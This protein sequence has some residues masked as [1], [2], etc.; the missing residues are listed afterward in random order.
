MKKHYYL[1]ALVILFLLLFI[2]NVLV[3]FQEGNPLPILLGII[4]V[5][6]SRGDIV[7]VSDTKLLQK[8]GPENSLSELLAINNWAYCSGTTRN[9]L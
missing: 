9:D 5:E 8:A 4:M 2:T 3:N 7:A 6:F 1:L